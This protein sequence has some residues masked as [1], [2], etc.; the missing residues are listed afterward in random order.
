MSAATIKDKIN[1]LIN[2]D[3]VYDSV[4]KPKTLFRTLIAMS[5]MTFFFIVMP[6]GIA[7]EQRHGFNTV[8]FDQFDFL[9]R[10][11]TP[12]VLV[13]LTS[14]LLLSY[15]LKNYKSKTGPLM[16]VLPPVAMALALAFIAAIAAS[17]LKLNNTGIRLSPQGGFHAL[18][19][20][21]FL[22]MTLIGIITP[23]FILWWTG[24]Y[25]IKAFRANSE[26]ASL[27]FS[28]VFFSAFIW[29]FIF[30][31][32]TGFNTD[33][34]FISLA[35]MPVIGLFAWLCAKYPPLLV[36][37]LNI[38]MAF[39]AFLMILTTVIGSLVGGIF[40]RR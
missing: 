25:F 19:A 8:V 9:T 32:F 1:V 21:F 11:M 28:P 20:I 4:N 7:L 18:Q 14:I 10:L 33:M 15:W 5:I 30:I 23:W 31:F 36:I 22:G 27:I 39:F 13:G 3:S 38:I 29:L 34:M 26:Q 16:T 35:C 2:G 24:G 40:N 37:T 17:I 6:W 12:L